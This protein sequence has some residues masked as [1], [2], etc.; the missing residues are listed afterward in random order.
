[1]ADVELHPLVAALAATLVSKGQLQASPEAVTAFQE[2]AQALSDGEREVVLTHL[3][4]LA[5]KV[6]RNGVED[7][8][9]VA[10]LA[11]LI[12]TLVPDVGQA[13]DAFAAAGLHKA[14]AVVGTVAATRAPMATA[15]P[16]STAPVQ[17]RRGLTKKA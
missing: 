17:A 5:L 12:L 4:A 15:S 6:R 1:M 9:F 3:L 8:A 16:P 13:R 2:G 11:V 10:V 14:A 7:E